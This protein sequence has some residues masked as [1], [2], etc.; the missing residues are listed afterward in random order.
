MMTISYIV[1]AK[2]MQNRQVTVKQYKYYEFSNSY[3]C[4]RARTAMLIN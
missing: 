1:D 4:H 3:T 2:I